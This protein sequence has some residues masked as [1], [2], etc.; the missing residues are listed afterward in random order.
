MYSVKQL[1]YNNFYTQIKTDLL[2]MNKAV[3]KAI[4][5]L[6]SQTNLA[7]ACSEFLNEEIK[8]GHVWNWSRRDKSLSVDVCFAI[9]HATK[10]EVKIEDLTSGYR[11]YSAKKSY[12][13]SNKTDDEVSL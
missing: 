9:E 1:L 4:K 7:L 3:D 8:Q 13:R 12:K 10:G 5:I 6:G 11:R 2:E